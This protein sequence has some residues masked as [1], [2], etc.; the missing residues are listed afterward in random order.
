MPEPV[1]TTSPDGVDYGW[2]MQVTFVVTILVGAPVVAMLSLTTEL[3][4]WGAR[5]E[6]AV[7]IGAVVWLLVSLSVF[8][9]AKRRQG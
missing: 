6:F 1:E 7:R 8:A 4:T 2:V 5:A 3:S 9:Y